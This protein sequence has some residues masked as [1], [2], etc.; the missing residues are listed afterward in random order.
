MLSRV[1]LAV[2]LLSICSRVEADLM[3]R[4]SF[5]RDYGVK[6]CGRE[7]IRAVIFT[8][9]GSRWRRSPQSGEFGSGAPVCTSVL[10]PLFTVLENVSL[11]LRAWNWIFD[12]P[13]APSADALPWTLGSDER[14]RNPAAELYEASPPRSSSPLDDLLAVH[15]PDRKRRNFSLGVAGKCCTQGCTKN[16]IGRLC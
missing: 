4:L 5:P 15:R 8:C 6:L 16:D 10:L 7:F 2:A 14:S 9:G 3:A 1:A 13:P 11:V 12:P